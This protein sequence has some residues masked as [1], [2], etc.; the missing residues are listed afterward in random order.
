[1]YSA[2]LKK[3]VADGLIT[4]REKEANLILDSIG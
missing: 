2:I 3:N 4:R 1:M